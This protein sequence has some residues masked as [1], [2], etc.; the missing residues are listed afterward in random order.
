MLK[1]QE[2]DKKPQTTVFVPVSWCDCLML[3]CPS[4]CDSPGCWCV[5]GSLHH[6]PSSHPPTSP[7]VWMI[8][9]GSW[10]LNQILRCPLSLFWERRLAPALRQADRPTSVSSSARSASPSP[11]GHPP[12]PSSSSSA[13]VFFCIHYIKIGQL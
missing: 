6:T 13:E 1:K 3:V 4:S 2:T 5:C 9:N 7:R 8:P 12:S 11:S 10:L